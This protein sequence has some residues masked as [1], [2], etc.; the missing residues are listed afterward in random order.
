M[1]HEEFIAHVRDLPV[2]DAHTHLV[3]SRLR[4]ADF[5]EIVHYFW[6]FREMQGAGYPAKPEEV[7]EDQRIDLFLE[8]WK[9]TKGTGMHYAVECIFR[10]LYN[11]EIAGRSSVLEGINLVKKSAADKEWQAAVVEKGRIANA[12]INEED[13][14]FEGLPGVCIYAPRVD[15]VL[16]DGPAR[17]YHAAGRKE[18][19]LRLRQELE[20]FINKAADRGVPGIMTTIPPL[21]KKTFGN[22]GEALADMD[23]CTIY[24]LRAMCACAAKRNLTVQFFL[25]VE[26]DWGVEAAPVNRTDRI[27]N[28]YGLFR[29]YSCPFDLVVASELNNMD[30]VQAAHIFPK[31]CVG[32]MWWY[33]F[34]PSTYRDAMAK[35]FETLA[36]NK[37]YLS[38][39][40]SRCIEWCYGKNTLIKKLAVNFFGEKVREG[41]VSYDDA[42]AIAADWFRGTQERLYRKWT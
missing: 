4:A 17:A 14:V 40:D 41:F 34:R 5:W 21:T 8:A 23:D 30:V 32:G 22:S 18:E 29:D 1:T 20:S 2:F 24:L 26:Y 42:L 13:T 7:P 15:H 36:S 19:A 6:F 10:D 39:S 16:R 35:R 33:N 11:L 12:V 27:I 37:S 28:L 25:G 9:K 3:G 31:V 38:V